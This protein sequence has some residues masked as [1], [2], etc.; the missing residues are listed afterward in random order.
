MLIPIDEHELLVFW[1]QL[2]VLLLFARILGVTAR[3]IGLPSVIG[4]LLAGL[5]LGPSIFGQLWPEGFE[6]F[7]PESETQSAAL[8]GISWIGLF[9]LLIATG[10]ETDLE[11]IRK[12][13]RPVAW[14]ATGSLLVPFTGGLVVGLM[15]P[16]ETFLGDDTSRVTFALFVATA[17]SVSALAVVAK[18]LSEM[19]MMR[20]DFGQITVAVGMA[21]DLVGW[22][23]L[24]VFA[25]VATS[26]SVSIGGIATTVGGIVLF[27]VFML[28]LGQRMV[29]FGL[30]YV[31]R[32]GENLSGALTVSILV[33]LGAGV[34]TQRLG[35][36]AVLGAFIAGVVLARSRF[37]HSDV[38]HNLE[39]L[40]FAVFAPL[41]F[42][43]AG[44]RID[45]ETLRSATALRW[46]VIVVLV[47]IIAKFIG[48]YVGARFAGRTHR[49]GMALGAGLNARG[50][51]EVVIATVG[52][53]L[54]VFSTTAFTVIVL[55]PVVT[56]IFAS[57]SLRAV[58]RNYQGTP[59]EIERLDREAALS[60]N[61][62]VRNHRLLVPSR[63]QPASI[64]AAQLLHLAWPS[65]ADVTVLS[66]GE[67][68]VGADIQ[69]LRNVLHGREVEHRVVKTGPPLAAVLKE[70]KL[71][72]GVIGL[73]AA[74]VTQGQL[75]SPF[76][77]DVLSEAPIPVVVVRRARNLDRP[78]PGAFSR[79]LV[80]VSATVGSRAAQEV[81]F[82]LGTQ[83][84]TELIVA[85]VEAPDGN[86]GM[87]PRMF[88][89]RAVPAAD[90]TVGQRLVEQ[91]L[92][93]AREIGVEAET[94]VRRSDHPGEELVRI[95]RQRE[96]DLVVVGTSLRRAAG[97][98]FLGKNVEYILAHCDATVAVVF[99]PIDL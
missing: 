60:R 57:V 76:V 10:F 91:S 58:V 45:L 88:H 83:L 77:D 8:L 34:I 90:A 35:V 42:A 4:E 19:G 20:R 64:A 38:R 85:H 5:L 32:S 17:L 98:P 68:G 97:K 59:D 69:P 6:W 62:V 43:T 79:A 13:G 18:I 3:K 36:E 51:L 30:R 82:N 53:E 37:Q 70:A 86:D 21:N 67:D 56:S 44:L 40:T 11:L 71:G 78:L 39:A 87:L 50:A 81:A 47:A 46:T 33:A 16:S 89:R 31:R 72:F 95:S 1:T 2:F 63:G 80:P 48:A 22:M 29:D 27:L 14:V 23:L 12:L 96:V 9:L 94:V 92:E 65:E 84:G 54:G 28:T 61:L 73:G 99:V 25:G 75:I 7:L 93:F 24:G 41:F 15:L 55:V 26:G 49:A 52:L 74:D 66:V